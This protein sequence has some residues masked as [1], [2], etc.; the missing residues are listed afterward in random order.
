MRIVGG[1]LKGRRFVTKHMPHARPTTDRAKESVFNILSQYFFWEELEVL[2]LFSGL[3]SLALESYSRGAKTVDAVDVNIKSV[4]YIAQTAGEWDATISVYKQDV[5][6]YLKKCTKRYDLIFADPPYQ[7]V[8]LLLET[9]KHVQ[10]LELLKPGGWLVVEHE[11]SQSVPKDFCFDQRV[12]G[13]STF[14]F[15]KFD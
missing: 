13:Q 5:L 4:K 14:S 7:K 9:I 15:F 12:Y 2:D 1:S 8:D 10:Q 3:G 11:T 6:K